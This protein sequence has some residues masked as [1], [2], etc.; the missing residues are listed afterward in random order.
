MVQRVLYSSVDAAA[1]PD[2]DG[3]AMTAS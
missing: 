3:D 1:V 2:G